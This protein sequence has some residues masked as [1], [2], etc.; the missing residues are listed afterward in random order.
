MGKS[1][2]PR[3]P[4]INKDNFSEIVGRDWAHTV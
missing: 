4:P 1:K 3:A 2:P